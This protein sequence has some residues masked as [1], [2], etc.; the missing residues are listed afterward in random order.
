MGIRYALF[1]ASTQPQ[2]EPHELGRAL[3]AAIRPGRPNLVVQIPWDLPVL[4]TVGTRTDEWTIVSLPYRFL[5]SL[6][7]DLHA[8]LARLPHCTGLLGFGQEDT[9]A[10]MWFQWLSGGKQFTYFEAE[11]SVQRQEGDIP[12]LPKSY[13]QTDWDRAVNTLL[14]PEL[15]FEAMRE[16]RF[17]QFEVQ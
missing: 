3:G 10:E 4:Q 12:V 11:G 9:N 13:G 17:T 16:L 14:P 5:V 6:R 8:V 1:A 15:Q 7:Y 2:L